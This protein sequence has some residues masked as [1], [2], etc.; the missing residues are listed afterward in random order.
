MYRTYD[1]GASAEDREV[2]E[3]GRAA[4]TSTRAEPEEWVTRFQQTT[5]PV[6]AKGVEDTAFYRHVRL[7][8][9]NDVGGDPGRFGISPSTSSTA[10]TSSAP[11]AFPRN[12]LVTQTHDTK[13]SGDVRARIG[14]LSLIAG[15]YV[16]LARSL[17]ADRG[18]PDELEQLFVLPDARR[19]LADLG[20]A[21]RR[22]PRE[23]AARGEADHELGR[24]RRGTSAR[25]RRTHAAASRR[26]LPAD[27][28]RRSPSSVAEA[29]HRS[30]MAQTLLKLTVPGVPDIYQ[31]D[32]LVSL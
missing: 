32:E 8:A 23:G 12:L 22:V 25:C 20:R 24:A 16:A 10:P 15:E 2:L 11:S 6:M 31:G 29:G 28:P 7:L 27:V 4:R 3:R 17:A 18:A 26:P 9:L 13:R 5:P 19:R 21:P 14:A 1:G 30:A